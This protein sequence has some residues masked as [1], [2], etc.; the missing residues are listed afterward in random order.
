M[1]LLTDTENAVLPNADAGGQKSAGQG[2]VVGS[3]QAGPNSPI[4]P[5]SSVVQ[6]HGWATPPSQDSAF[7]EQGPHRY[8]LLTY[9]SDSTDE[10]HDFLSIVVFACWLQMNPKM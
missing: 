6:D 2:G 9:L 1:R 10:V 5:Q 8:R 7:S 4:T 3:E